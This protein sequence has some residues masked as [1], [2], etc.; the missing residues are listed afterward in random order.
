MNARKSTHFR[1]KYYSINGSKKRDSNCE[2]R[3]LQ[4]SRE[5][6]ERIKTKQLIMKALAAQLTTIGRFAKQ[7]KRNFIDARHLKRPS[8]SAV[9]CWQMLLV[10]LMH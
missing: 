1:P 10:S 7:L 3:K 2:R 4:A 6:R 5:G 9:G 8:R